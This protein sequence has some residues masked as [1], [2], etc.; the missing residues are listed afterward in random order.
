ERRQ[1][2]LD[3]RRAA[4]DQARDL[5]AVHRGAA[6]HGGDVGLVVLPD[7]GGVGAGHGTLVAHPGDGDR[8]VETSGEGDADAFADG[9]TGEDL[10]HAPY[11]MRTFACLYNRGSPPA[12]DQIAQPSGPQASA[13]PPTIWT[14]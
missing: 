11:F 9:E 4:V 12:Q 10:G 6:G 14:V 13:S 3:E 5:R 7:V 2:L 8:G 1:A